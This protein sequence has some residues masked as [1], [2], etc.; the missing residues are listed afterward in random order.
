MFFSFLYIHHYFF[1]N[2]SD[3]DKQKRNRS[4]DLFFLCLCSEIVIYQQNLVFAGKGNAPVMGKYVV[5]AVGRLQCN[6]SLC[7]LVLGKQTT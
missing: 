5:Y 1:L 6:S 4:F 2:V 3:Q 7:V